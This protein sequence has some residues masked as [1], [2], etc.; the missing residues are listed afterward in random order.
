MLTEKEKDIF[1]LIKSDR[2]LSI[3]DIA[4]ILSISVANV[5][6]ALRSLKQKEYI[7]HNDLDASDK[8]NILKY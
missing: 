1:E 4:E 8:W 5:N 6:S 7:R 3:V 2:N